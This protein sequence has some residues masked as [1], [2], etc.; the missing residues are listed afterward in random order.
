MH[1][2]SLALL[3]LV[4]ATAALA[5]DSNKILIKPTGPVGPCSV[6][7][8]KADWPG[9]EWGDGVK[10]GRLSTVE[11]GGGKLFHVDYTVGEIGPEKG[12]ISW[13]YPIGRS[14]AAEM[15]YT[16]RFSKDFDWV[17]GGKLPGLCGGPSNVSGGKPADGTNGLPMAVEK[18]MYIT[19]TSV[20]IMGI[21]SH[22]L[23]TSVFPQRP[24]S[25][26][27]YAWK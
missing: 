5:S 19:R 17:R 25:G 24:M 3:V 27:A 21:A 9:C 26:C 16:V 12:G 6:A 18:P 15:T 1:P 14:E 22:S 11:R 8:W 20:I 13:R 2:R 10:Q 4:V 23:P 7:Q